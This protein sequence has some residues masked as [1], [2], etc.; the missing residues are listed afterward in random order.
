MEFRLFTLSIGILFVGLRAENKIKSALVSAE[1]PSLPLFICQVQQL[2][3]SLYVELNKK[4]RM[5][6]EVLSP[7]TF[8]F[9]ERMEISAQ[10]RDRYCF[11]FLQLTALY[12]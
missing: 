2:S 6:W 11:V 10:T 4:I 7:E 9:P 3:L 1:A 5:P 12:H 8:F